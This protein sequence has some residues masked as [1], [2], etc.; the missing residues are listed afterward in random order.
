MTTTI[1]GVRVFDGQRLTEHT[2]VRIAGGLIEAVGGLELLRAGDQHLEGH[3]G[4]LL[5]GL[6]DAHIHLLPGA[7][8]QALSFGVT[9]VLDMFSKPDS[10]RRAVAQG[11]GPDAAEVRSSSIGATAPGGHPTMMYA[12]FPYVTGPR[13]AEAFVADRLAEGAHHLK[14]LYDDGAGGGPMPMPSLDIPT[15]AALVDAAHRAALIVVAHVTTARAAVDLLPTGVD[16]LAHVPFDRLTDAHVGAI[17]DAGVAVIATLAVADGFPGDGEGMPLLAEPELVRR[18][19]PAWS[20]VIQRQAQRWLPPQLPDFAAPADNVGLL[21]DAGVPV[22]AG[23]DAPNPG[24]VHGAGVHRE[25]QRLVAAGL[26][27]D[28][29]LAAATARTADV[30][31]LADRGRIR[32][33]LRADLVLVDG[34]PDRRITDTHRVAAVW[35]HGVRA[36]LDTYIGSADEDAGLAALRAQTDKVIAAVQDRLPQIIP[37]ARS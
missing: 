23:T 34:R 7:P 28:Q 36:D 27:P 18:L 10:V 12:P 13:D 30:F 16:V 20:G 15:V 35:K 19:G 29:A 24:T 11:A 31:G 2:A 33:G 6:I 32:P 17:S 9:T 26:A 25:L 22:L 37:G 14:V 8:R 1:T 4:T 21:H 5:P 3:G